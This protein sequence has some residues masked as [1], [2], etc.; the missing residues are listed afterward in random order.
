MDGW[1]ANLRASE[2]PRN[3]GGRCRQ[4]YADEQPKHAYCFQMETTGHSLFKKTLILFIS[5]FTVLALGFESTRLFSRS[6]IHSLLREMNRLIDLIEIL[7]QHG[8]PFL[9]RS[10]SG[11]GPCAKR[12]YGCGLPFKGTRPGDYAY[13]SIEV[14]KAAK[15]SLRKL[16]QGRLVKELSSSLSD[17]AWNFSWARRSD[18]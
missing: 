12:G 7:L 18:R 1:R 16:E 6:L 17:L 2:P 5:C 11:R 10:T 13:V 8:H 3:F 15:P 9:Q 4:S 14:W